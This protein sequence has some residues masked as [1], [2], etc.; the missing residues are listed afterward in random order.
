[1][2]DTH[3]QSEDSAPAACRRSSRE[4]QQTQLYDPPVKESRPK[5]RKTAGKIATEH[6]QRRKTRMQ[7]PRMATAT[8]VESSTASQPKKKGRPADPRAVSACLLVLNG[9]AATVVEAIGK[10]KAACG[11]R[12]VRKMLQRAKDAASEIEDLV[13][14]CKQGMVRQFPVSGFAFCAVDGGFFSVCVSFFCGRGTQNFGIY[15]KILR[16]PE[17]RPQAGGP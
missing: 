7:P 17:P 9:S 6:A 12:N 3:N 15:P 13:K 1:M 14:S 4:K 16:P 11:E 8:T 2:Y 5:R 10:A